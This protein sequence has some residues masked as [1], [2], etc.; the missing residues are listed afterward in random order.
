MEAQ[1]L[2]LTLVPLTCPPATTCQ[3]DYFKAVVEP[4]VVDLAALPA[5]ATAAASMANVVMAYGISGSGKT[6]SIEVR[7]GWACDTAVPPSCIH[8]C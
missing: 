2:E 1:P 7:G 6:F 5:P 3:A 8:S 4:I